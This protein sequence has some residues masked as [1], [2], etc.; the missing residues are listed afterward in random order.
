MDFNERQ[1][2]NIPNPNFAILYSRILIKLL[3]LYHASSERGKYNS[4]LK[5]LLVQKWTNFCPHFTSAFLYSEINKSLLSN[6]K[7]SHLKLMEFRCLFLLLKHIIYRISE[8]IFIIQI[9]WRLHLWGFANPYL[10]LSYLTNL[11]TVAIISTYIFTKNSFLNGY[12]HCVRF[13][14]SL[15]GQTSWTWTTWWNFFGWLNRIGNITNNCE[16]HNSFQIFVLNVYLSI[17]SIYIEPN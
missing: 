8:S 6:K 7:L 13:E 5:N 2:A 12:H 15:Q 3:S 10:Y 14:E 16:L 11:D 4:R 1:G 17:Y 9:C